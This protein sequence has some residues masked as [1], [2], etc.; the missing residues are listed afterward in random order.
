MHVPAYMEQQW[1]CEWLITPAAIYAVAWGPLLVLMRKGGCPPSAISTPTGW[2]I[3]G[4]ESP[5]PW[6]HNVRSRGETRGRA[7]VGE[8]TAVNETSARSGQR[9]WTT[10]AVPR[11]QRSDTRDRR[12]SA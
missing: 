10:Q 5:P 6:R 1:I 8:P 7:E 12:C 9:A 3:H 11:R 2:L 4:S